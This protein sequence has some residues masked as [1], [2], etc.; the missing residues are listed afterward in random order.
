[1]FNQ[2]RDF[3]LRNLAVDCVA[4]D[5]S[6]SSGLAGNKHHPETHNK[7]KM[8]SPASTYDEAVRWTKASGVSLR[9][10]RVAQKTSISR[11]KI[12]SVLTLLE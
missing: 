4:N 5:H 12:D 11:N 10:A 7:N 3:R 9:L 1:M 6:T 8:D 2:M